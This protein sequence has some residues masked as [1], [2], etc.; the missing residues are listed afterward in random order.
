MQLTQALTDLLSELM[1]SERDGVKYTPRPAT[2]HVS[3]RNRLR[4]ARQ[5][6]ARG[7]V[8][9]EQFGAPEEGIFIVKTVTML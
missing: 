9:I 8:R 3:Q 6:E 2:L 1:G 5:L 7:L 4:Q